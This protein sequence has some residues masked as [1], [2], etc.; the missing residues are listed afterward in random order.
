MIDGV[1]ARTDDTT[2]D[3]ATESCTALVYCM[4]L[5]ITILCLTPVSTKL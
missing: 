1:V 4:Q 3:A 2:M 5:S